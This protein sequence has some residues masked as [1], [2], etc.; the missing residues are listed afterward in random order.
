MSGQSGITLLELLVVVAVSAVIL[1]VGAM[2]TVPWLARE[3]M[4]G[5]VRDARGVGGRGQPER[6][7]RVRKRGAA[8]GHR[9]ADD[10][11]LG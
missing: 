5:A 11:R 4:R 8:V 2:A 1:A 3:S 9:T 6:Q 10:E 7:H